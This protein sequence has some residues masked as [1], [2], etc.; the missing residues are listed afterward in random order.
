MTLTFMVKCKDRDSWRCGSLRVLVVR[1]VERGEPSLPSVWSSAACWPCRL[2][3]C[4]PAARSSPHCQA[5]A[6]VKGTWETNWCFRVESEP[7]MYSFL[8]AQF[9]FQR[10]FKQASFQLQYDTF[11]VYPAPYACYSWSSLLSDGAL[12]AN[13]LLSSL[14]VFSSWYLEI[15]PE[16]EQCLLL[17][18][19]LLLRACSR[20]PTKLSTRQAQPCPGSLQTDR[21][22]AQP[23]AW[24]IHFYCF[25]WVCSCQGGSDGGKDEALFRQP[26][27]NK[28][29]MHNRNHL[30]I[31]HLKKCI[32]IV[33]QIYSLWH[34]L[35][36]PQTPS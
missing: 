12:M 14:G 15:P 4:L 24:E 36:S 11:L 33:C 6:C 31:I 35:S 10:V 13:T 29:W 17:A 23:W 32:P 3:K 18:G 22:T 21:Q 19:E 8:Y 2:P 16:L 28:Q 1:F 27:I 5:G 34:I 25:I 26:L 30:Q 9:L 20:T 7:L